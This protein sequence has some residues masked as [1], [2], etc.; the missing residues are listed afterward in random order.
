MTYIS[1]S[2]D[3]QQQEDGPKFGYYSL[4]K[5]GRSSFVPIVG[6]LDIIHRPDFVYNNVMDSGLCLRT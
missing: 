1:L 6:L 3:N 5:R 2:L 4:E